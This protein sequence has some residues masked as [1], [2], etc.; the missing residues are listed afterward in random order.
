MKMISKFQK[1]D[2]TY[3]LS[4][5]TLFDHLY[6]VAMSSYNNTQSAR[7]NAGCNTID[8]QLGKQHITKLFKSTRSRGR[9]IGY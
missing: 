9:R 5:Q 7:V 2:Y 8:K 3:N 1:E 4:K 6:N